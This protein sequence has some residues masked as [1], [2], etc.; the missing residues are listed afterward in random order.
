MQIL[1]N[2]LG[3]YS[4]AI[5]VSLI[6]FMAV[7]FLMVIII[8]YILLQQH[9]RMYRFFGGSAKRRNLEVMLDD[10]LKMAQRIEAKYDEVLALTDDINARMI[11]CVRKVGMVRYNPFNDMGGDHSFVIA[12]L[13][14]NDDGIVISTLHAREASHTYAKQVV[15]GGSANELTEEEEEAV[16]LALEG[17]PIVDIG[18][19]LKKRERRVEDLKKRQER[20]ERL[21]EARRPPESEVQ[22]GEP[23]S[24]PR[25][26]LGTD[27]KR[28]MAEAAA[29]D[30]RKL[31]QDEHLRRRLAE[32]GAPPEPP[33]ALERISRRP[34]RMN[35]EDEPTKEIE[36]LLI[37]PEEGEQ[38]PTQEEE[39]SQEE[40]ENLQALQRLAAKLQVAAQ[41]QEHQETKPFQQGE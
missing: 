8:T 37:L 13:D 14:E 29:R 39:L 5:T 27:R 32:L 38:A 3:E 34:S 4:P 33:G 24:K 2:A 7:L 20:L 26:P 35:E 41:P 11:T 12:L 25:K 10:Y 31:A 15:Q 21:H 30:V 17:K 6:V 36:P 22:E 9:R 18:E 40:I 16:Q 1:N 28:I 19:H 23:Q